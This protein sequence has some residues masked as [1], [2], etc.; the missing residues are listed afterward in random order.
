MIDKIKKIIQPNSITE[1]LRQ[2]TYTHSWDIKWFISDEL[3]MIG[4]QTFILPNN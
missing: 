4:K 2:D 3:K 1:M